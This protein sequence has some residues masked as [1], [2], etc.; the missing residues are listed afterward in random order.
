[1]A[2]KKEG[3][4]QNGSRYRSPELYLNGPW[5]LVRYP[6]SVPVVFLV[7]STALAQGPLRKNVLIINEVGLAHPATHW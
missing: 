1:M 3:V 2:N 7:A 4:R 6:L 5:Q